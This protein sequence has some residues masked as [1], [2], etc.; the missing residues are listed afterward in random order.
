MEMVPYF[1]TNSIHS[2]EYFMKLFMT[3]HQDYDYDQ[4]CD[5]IESLQREQDDSI[6]DFN[7]KIM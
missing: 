4:S 3:M 2:W 5:E 6:D 7:S 1:P